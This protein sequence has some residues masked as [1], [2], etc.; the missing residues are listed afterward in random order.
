ML[1]RETAVRR[2]TTFSLAAVFLTLLICIRAEAAEFVPTPEEEQIQAC[3]AMYSASALAGKGVLQKGPSGPVW[4]V[5]SPAAQQSLFADADLRRL[6][7]E[8]SPLPVCGETDETFALSLPTEDAPSQT[9]TLRVDKSALRAAEFRYIPL[10]ALHVWYAQHPELLK[11]GLERVISAS[12]DPVGPAGGTWN[13]LRTGPENTAPFV[14]INLPGGGAP[15]IRIVS[16]TG[17]WFEL[18]LHF[19]FKYNAS[20]Q[21]DVCMMSLYEKTFQGFWKAPRDVNGFPLLFPA[22][23]RDPADWKRIAAEVGRGV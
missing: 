17:E 3:L 2:N 18:E 8:G 11:N 6:L 10:D 20:R 23:L 1:E 21:P 7:E 4:V 12:P 5:K 13:I 16:R 14:A 22:L 9:R 15:Q 19:R